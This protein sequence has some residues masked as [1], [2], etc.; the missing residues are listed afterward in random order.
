ME[1]LSKSLEETQKIAVE[2]AA[3]LIKGSHI[4]T[5]FC[6]YGNL[7]SGKTTFVQTVAKSLGIKEIVQS[8]TFVIMKSYKLEAVS[9]KL[10]I[11]IDAYRLKSGEELRK[12]GWN[13]ISTNPGNLIFIEWPDNA[14]DVIPTNAIKIK[15]KFIDE[16]TRQIT[17]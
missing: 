3:G 5:V 8:P 14:A 1:I 2:F 15:F 12:L 4:A 6:L 10:L 16:N 17:F 7:G 13:E 11:H 9:H